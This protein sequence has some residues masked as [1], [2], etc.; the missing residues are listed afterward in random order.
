MLKVAS[1]VTVFLP[2]VRCECVCVC[3]CVCV[4][5]FCQCV[6]V[7]VC[8]CVWVY[9][10]LLSENVNCFLWGKTTVTVTLH[11]LQSV[12]SMLVAFCPSPPPPLIFHRHTCEL[13]CSQVTWLRLQLWLI[14]RMSQ[15]SL[16]TV[17]KFDALPCLDYVS[18]VVI[19]LT[20]QTPLL[21]SPARVHL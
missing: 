9:V 8:V 7:C 16:I 10:L 14:L 3:V 1:V 18:A 5:F 12:P 4:Y 11:S 21:I 2:S 19:C 13:F 15:I 17:V 6:C 20:W